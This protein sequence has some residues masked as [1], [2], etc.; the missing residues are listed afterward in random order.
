[1]TNKSKV[2]K[3]TNK[4]EPK[5]AD[6]II[7]KDFH[8]KWCQPCKM[9]DQIIEKL[10]EEYAEKIIFETID[11]D[12][13]V[14]IAKEF[15]IMAVPTLIIEKNGVVV[16]RSVGITSKKSLETKINKLL[17]VITE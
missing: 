11:I 9:Q 5:Q 15:K 6:I 10:K 7:L 13:N 8:A 3:S 17:K 4:K 2:S 1:M 14:E 12:E 16:S